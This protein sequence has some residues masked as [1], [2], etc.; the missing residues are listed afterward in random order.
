ML[1]SVTG[2]GWHPRLL[3]HDSPKV[4][5]MA[6]ALYEPFFA[7]AVHAEQDAAGTPNFQYILT[8]TEPPPSELRE[9]QYVVLRLYAS[10]PDG[11][12]FMPGLLNSP[13]A[14]GRYHPTGST[15]TDS[16][17]SAAPKILA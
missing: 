4:T 15:S 8:T 14:L 13:S 3:I 1:W 10:S 6:P 5:D 12:L 17:Y 7:L 16:N 9:S 2:R 11:L